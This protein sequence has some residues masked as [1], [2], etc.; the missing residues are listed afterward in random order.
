MRD[1]QKVVMRK[2][3]WVWMTKKEKM[4][5][6]LDQ[7]Q[8]VPTIYRQLQKWEMNEENELTINVWREFCFEDFLNTFQKNWKIKRMRNNCSITFIREPGIDTAGVSP[9]F[10]SGFVGIFHFFL[11][12]LILKV[13][14]C[15]PSLTVSGTGIC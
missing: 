15:G 3:Q 9:D 8:L 5:G 14:Y 6:H 10:Y 7:S 2:N 4:R 12:S 13:V 1:N 11:F